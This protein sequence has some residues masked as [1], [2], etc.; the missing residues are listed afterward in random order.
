MRA[1]LPE[2]VADADVH[3]HYAARWLE[4]GGIRANMVVSVDGAAAAGGLSAGLQTP[5]DNRV[6]AALR[7]LADVVLVGSG[8][9]AAENYG[10]ASP[11]ADRRH[12]YGMPPELPIAVISRSLHLALDGRLFADA[13][14]RPLVITCGGSGRDARAAVG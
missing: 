14:P 9:A 11:D 12:A 10:P 1:L 3:A 7:D 6:F 8:T 2:P 5:G 4:R 13:A